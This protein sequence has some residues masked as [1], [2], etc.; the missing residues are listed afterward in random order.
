[1][2]S[3]FMDIDKQI[4]DDDSMQKT[5]LIA[6]KRYISVAE[7]DINRKPHFTAPRAIDMR[8][9]VDPE[10]R[11]AVDDLLF[12]LYGEENPRKLD[13]YGKEH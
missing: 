4:I 6:L 11:K 8:L 7:T 1:M 9:T 2:L 13:D 5:S 10:V 3:S 12:D